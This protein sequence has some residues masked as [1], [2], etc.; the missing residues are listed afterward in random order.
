MK[1]ILLLL[2]IFLSAI[3][4][5]YAQST[6]SVVHLKTGDIIKGTIFDYAPNGAIKIKTLE[7]LTLT[8]QKVEIENI[9][10]EKI[11]KAAIPAKAEPAPKKFKRNRGYRG[12]YD[13]GGAF[14]VG[15]NGDGI[16]AIH[17]TH[18]YQINPYFF[19]GAGIGF[20]YHFRDNDDFEYT[21]I[22]VPLYGDFRVNFLKKTISPFLDLKVG[23]SAFDGKG[24]YFNPNI[25]V[26]FGLKNEA[27]MNLGIGFNMQKEV[28]RRVISFNMI[29]SNSS[30]R[31]DKTIIG[32]ICIKLGVEF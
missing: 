1:K 32:G 8:F 23:Y 18:G 30:N 2:C 7:G 20:D 16:F 31:V 22:F 10:R 17:T 6:Q 11:D 9:S 13:I 28:T 24:F 15:H 12:F 29:D 25:G 26:S 21:Y 19:I 3:S 14:P 5:T 4:S 27:A